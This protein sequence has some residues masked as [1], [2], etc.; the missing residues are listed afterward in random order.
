MTDSKAET[1]GKAAPEGAEWDEDDAQASAAVKELFVTLAKALRAVQLYDENNPVYRRFVTALRESFVGLWGEVD[2]LRVQV[3]EDR[4]VHCGAEVYRAQSR[5]DSLAFLFFKDGIRTITFLPGV[6]NEELEPFLG[7]LQSARNLKPDGDDL[8]TVLWE[9]E[10]TCFQYQYVDLLAEGVALPE[11][12][13][14][15][16]GTP[17]AE[18][19]QAELPAE[20]E[21]EDAA[22]ADGSAAPQRQTVSSDDFNPTLYS[23]DPREK[24]EIRLEVEREGNRDLRGDVL[25]ALFDRLEEPDRPDRQSEILAIIETLLPNF[26]SKGGVASADMVLE[27]L[28]RAYEAPGV[29]DDERK[30]AVDAILDSLSS[31]ET[32]GELVRAIADGSIAPDP[33]VL[34]KFLLHLRPSALATLVKASGTILDPALQAS[35]VASVEGIARHSTSAVLELFSDPDP[36]VVSGAARLVGQIRVAGAAPY[37]AAILRHSDPTVRLAAIEATLAINATAAAEGLSLALQ[38]PDRDVRIA[39]ARAIGAMRHGGSAAALSEIIRGKG[40][41]QV[42]V[43]EKIVFF[44]AY[45]L[46]GDPAS[47]KLLDK[48]L[49]GKGFLGRREH[50]EIR[51]CAALALGKVD[52]KVARD[53]LEKARNEEDPVIRNAV[54]KAL[55]GEAR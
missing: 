50:P 11:A 1:P 28:A 7:V 34:G 49:N 16:P 24:E 44:E 38:D 42:D 41:R 39:A 29:L 12:G 32:I 51:A 6:E 36:A 30:G 10:F 45:G 3:E 9:H 14:A 55:G 22:S 40:I 47:V 23:L 15:E 20:G 5:A 43:T 18:V 37:L 21:D 25:L 54:L 46:V 17:P 53:V 52:S 13:T 31:P 27:E 8:L 19:L 48:F 26:L 33:T 35:V 2:D 4:L